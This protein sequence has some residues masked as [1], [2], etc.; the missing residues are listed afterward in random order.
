MGDPKLTDGQRERL[1][2]LEEMV[3]A[4]QRGEDIS[5]PA[6]SGRRWRTGFGWKR[7]WKS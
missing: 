7:R 5:Y 2:K 3:D 6:S 4:I 1:K